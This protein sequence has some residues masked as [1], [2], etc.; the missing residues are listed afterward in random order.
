MQSATGDDWSDQLYTGIFGCNA[1]EA[2]DPAYAGQKSILYVLRCLHCA[3][4]ARLTCIVCYGSLAAPTRSH[5][6]L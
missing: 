2:S 5:S 1:A 4:L 6:A 3:W